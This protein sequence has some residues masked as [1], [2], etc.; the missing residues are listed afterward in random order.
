MC[1]LV[2]T[3]P[4]NA[5]VNRGHEKWKPII[6]SI[7]E[8]YDSPTVQGAATLT[9]S[10]TVLTPELMALGERWAQGDP[11][12]ELMREIDCPT[13]LS[14]DIVGALRRAKDMV[15]QVRAVYFDDEDRRKELSA[16]IRKV[17]RDEVE[18]VF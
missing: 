17:T 13:D 5:R 2:Q 8:V 3:L 11:L 14:G 4:R 7:F 10:E 15:S 18:A 1:G 9:N 12:S 6:R 16:L